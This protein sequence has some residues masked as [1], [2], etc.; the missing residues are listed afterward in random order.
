MGSY[1][2]LGFAQNEG[3]CSHQTVKEIRGN[4]CGL[5]SPRKELGGLLATLI[6]FRV[7]DFVFLY[8]MILYSSSQC[9]TGTHEIHRQLETLVAQFVGKESALVF[10]MGFATNSLNLP[11]LVDE[12]RLLFLFSV[13]FL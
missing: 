6:V 10:G 8:Y 2:Y 11:A 1:N 12:V 4:G 7:F 9:F 13:V 5:A 3:Y